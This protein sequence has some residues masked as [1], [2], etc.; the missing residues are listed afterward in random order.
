MMGGCSEKKGKIRLPDPEP[1]FLVFLSFFRSRDPPPLFVSFQVN[2]GVLYFWIRLK[3][4]ALLVVLFVLVLIIN[5]KIHVFYHLPLAA[6]SLAPPDVTNVIYGV[7]VCV[8]VYL[9]NCT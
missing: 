9:L 3:A 4:S 6:L 8:C 5:P 2:T 7:C 1:N